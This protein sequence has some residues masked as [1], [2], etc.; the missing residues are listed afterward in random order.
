MNAK[1]KMK[2]LIKD[3]KSGNKV[4]HHTVAKNDGKFMRKAPILHK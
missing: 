4:K 1:E 2:A 3:K